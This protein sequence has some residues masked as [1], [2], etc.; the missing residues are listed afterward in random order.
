MSQSQFLSADE[1]SPSDINVDMD[2][3]QNDRYYEKPKKKLKSQ[4][5]SSPLE[6]STTN[7]TLSDLFST[8]I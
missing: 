6:Y 5:A 8:T 4:I 7:T 1:I 3:D 2:D